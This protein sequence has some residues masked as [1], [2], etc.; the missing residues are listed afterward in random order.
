MHNNLVRNRVIFLIVLSY[1]ISAK[2]GLVNILFSIG[3]GAWMMAGI[4]KYL[5]NSADNSA[6]LSVNEFIPHRFMWVGLLLESTR[7]QT[8]LILAWWFSGILAAFLTFELLKV[9][10][11]PS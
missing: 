8:F 2:N 1:V 4:F 9:L 10:L 7:K 5:F 11:L 6:N 3:V